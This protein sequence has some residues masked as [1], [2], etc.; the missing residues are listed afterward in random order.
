LLRRPF[1]PLTLTIFLAAPVAAGAQPG[2]ASSR[3]L[4]DHDPSWDGA[5]RGALIGAGSMAGLLTIGYARCDAGCEAPARLPTYFRG[6]S[7]GAGGGAAIGWVID[8]LHKAPGPPRLAVALRADRQARAV[9]MH[10]SF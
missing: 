2:P 1:R 9:V 4:T 7:V 3:P 6:M 5:A 10:W 8:R